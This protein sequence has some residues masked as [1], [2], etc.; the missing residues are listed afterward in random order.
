MIALR[1]LVRC[2]HLK[3]ISNYTLQSLLFALRQHARND[4]TQAP[5][6]KHKVR[7]KS[8]SFSAG[9]RSS[10]CGLAAHRVKVRR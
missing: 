3:C 4:E 6:K 2:S 7:R 10:A 5:P 1:A 9:V 8:V